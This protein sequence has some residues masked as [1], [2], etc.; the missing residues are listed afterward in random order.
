M[1][2]N[3]SVSTQELARFLGWA[4]LGLGVPQTTM[5]GRFDRA[6]GIEDDDRAR[7]ITRVAC[8]LRELA[9]AAGI[10]KLEWPRPTTF[11]WAR[12]A[13][14]ALD[15]TL[16]AAAFATRRR[17]TGRLAVATG[18]VVAITA[19][20]VKAALDLSRAPDGRA[21]QGTPESNNEEGTNPMR[22]RTAATVRGSRQDIERRWQEWD[23]PAR[24]AGV[25][26]ADA[27]GDRG[28]EIHL[29]IEYDLKAGVL[30]R[31]IAIVQGEEPGLKVNEDLRRFKQW[32]ETGEVVRSDGTPEGA[33]P[34]RLL[35]QRPAQPLQAAEPRAPMGVSS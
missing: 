23:G 32:V 14:D 35:K 3:G 7:T 19:A 28:T 15:L 5:P 6:I 29:D 1:S 27:P 17:S 12:V 34:K 26:F 20:D 30:G 33:T 22:Y 13:G 4:S 31:T 11:L 9:A 21:A 18:A 25:R 16:L 24:Q 10:L 2:T 8:G